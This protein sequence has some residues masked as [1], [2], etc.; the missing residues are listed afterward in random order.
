MAVYRDEFQPRPGG[1]DE[2]YVIAAAGV[3]AADDAETAARQL[4]ITR[5]Q[6]VRLLFGR[7]RNLTEAECDA[8]LEGP[9]GRQVD[10]MLRYAAVGTPHDV[11]ARLADFAVHARA[12]ELM[13]APM[14]TDRE[15]WLG[16]VA[17]LAPPAAD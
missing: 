6:R 11:Q 8:L 15:I 1:A 3:I 14:A 10:E 2:P 12:D 16:T 4:D 9:A 5:R 7:G 13:L 17:A